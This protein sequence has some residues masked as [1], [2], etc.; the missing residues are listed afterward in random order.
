[1]RHVYTVITILS[2]IGFF[3]G[4]DSL[5][6]LIKRKFKEKFDE[7]VTWIKIERGIE[8]GF[9]ILTIAFIFIMA[10]IALIFLCMLL[11]NV[12]ML[13]YNIF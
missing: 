13:I 4:L 5:T 8:I 6:A 2:V 1:M 11:F 9:N 12:Y 10:I 7:N 3:V